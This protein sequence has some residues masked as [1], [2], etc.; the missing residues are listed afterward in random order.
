MAQPAR[1]ERPD[2]RVKGSG[3]EKR[4][5]APIPLG[6]ARAK[7]EAMLRLYVGG[8]ARRSSLP[9]PP[10]PDR[11]AGE[12][13]RIGAVWLL[14]PLTPVPGSEPKGPGADCGMGL[15][16]SEIAS[17]TPPRRDVSFASV[18]APRQLDPLSLL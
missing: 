12:A 1:R 17:L 6:E 15:G 16:V 18:F 9:L 8:S 7:P 3:D 14:V 4:R 10:T 11:L 2:H 5:P 13:R